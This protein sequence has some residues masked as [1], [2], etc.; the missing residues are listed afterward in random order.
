MSA[1]LWL[2]EKIETFSFSASYEGVCGMLIDLDLYIFNAVGEVLD[3]QPLWK[4]NAVVALSEE[5]LRDARVMIGPPI[6]DSI[7]GPITMDTIRDRQ[8][9]EVGFRVIPENRS[10]ALFAVPEAVWSKWQQ[11]GS[12]NRRR[13][14]LGHVDDFLFL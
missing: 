5:E 3:S 14:N 8:G 2:D 4:G 13:E 12:W 9:F 7:R 6:H 10:V 1:N 11:S